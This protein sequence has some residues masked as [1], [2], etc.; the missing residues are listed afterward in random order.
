MNEYYKRLPKKRI[1]AGAL[2]FNSKNQLLIVK[3]NYRDRW[4]IPG[5]IVEE[6]ESPR[7]GCQREI[8]E[9]LDLIIKVKNPVCVDYKVASSQKPDGVY[10]LFDI[11]VI[12]EKTIEVIS[13]QNDELDEFRF[14]NQELLVEML[15]H[16]LHERVIHYLKRD[17]N[18]HKLCEYLENGASLNS[19]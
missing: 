19:L 6:N 17:R 7:Q 13:I 9:E 12:N 18:D 4:L 5:G 8:K 10:F 14:I 15:E 3:P 16:G 1:A 11:G 2:I